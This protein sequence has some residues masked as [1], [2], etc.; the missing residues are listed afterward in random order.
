MLGV[1]IIPV[2]VVICRA[3]HV[4]RA[5][6]PKESY[7]G[8]TLGWDLRM[9]IYCIKYIFYGLCYMWHA[10]GSAPWVCITI[11]KWTEAFNKLCA[12]GYGQ[13][14]WRSYDEMTSDWVP[15]KHFFGNA[16]LTSKLSLA[17][18]VCSVLSCCQFLILRP[19]G[20]RH[21]YLAISLTPPTPTIPSYR[22]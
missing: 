13:I 14:V 3:V 10:H 22:R 15:S 18:F 17:D 9:G 19:S 16:L 5:K 12:N 1:D 21:Q 4:R 11:Y 6:N 2:L 8:S 7:I 20:W